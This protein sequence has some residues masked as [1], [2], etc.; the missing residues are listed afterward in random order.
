[1]R[2]AEIQDTQN[3]N[4]R[5]PHTWWLLGSPWVLDA[6]RVQT[7]LRFVLNEPGLEVYHFWSFHWP[8]LA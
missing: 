7:K 8:K 6:E 2:E 4:V 1:M 5:T 3:F